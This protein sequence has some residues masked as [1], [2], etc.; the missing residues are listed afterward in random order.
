[1]LHIVTVCTGNVCRSPLASYMLAER[2]ADLNIRVTSA[3][4]GARPGMPMPHEA[5]RLG[6]ERGA[7]ARLLGQH[8]AH[9][10]TKEQLRDAD[11]VLAM[12]RSHRRAVVEIYPAVARKTFAVREFARL[13]ADVSDDQVRAA[14][15]QAGS[16]AAAPVRGFTSAIAAVASRRG[17]TFAPKDLDEEDVVD[18]FGRSVQTYERALDQLEPGLVAVER[19][20]RLAAT[21]L[22]EE[23]VV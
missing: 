5:I 4:T 22:S 21:Q 17:I 8:R 18:P 6:T 9:V 7:S 10:V 2:L 3:G 15:A 12:A 14:V 19:V 20:V 11:L 13:A 23:T 16:G 1:M